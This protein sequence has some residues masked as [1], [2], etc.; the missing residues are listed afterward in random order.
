MFEKLTIDQKQKL[1][2]AVRIRFLPELEV[3]R[4]TAINAIIERAIFI[5]QSSD[6]QPTINAIRDLLNKCKIPLHIQTIEEGVESLRK[7]GRISLNKKKKFEAWY[8]LETGQN[9]EIKAELE[10]SV[11]IIQKVVVRLFEPLILNEKRENLLRKIFIQLLSR[12][13]AELGM[14]WIK[15]Q[16]G[17]VTTRNFVDNKRFNDIIVESI[18][19]S[20]F[21]LSE[22]AIIRSKCEEFFRISDP[23]F[24]ALKFNFGQGYFIS[25]I[26]G[27]QSNTHILS[28]T[29]FS[30][31]KLWL[32]TNVLIIALLEGSKHY[33]TFH[34]LLEICKSVGIKLFA[35]R[36]TIIETL[37]VIEQEKNLIEKLYDEIPEDYLKTHRCYD[38]F[39]ETYR[40]KK[41]KDENY[42]IHTLFASFDNIE[43]LLPLLGILIE[44]IINDEIIAGMNSPILIENIQ[45]CSQEIRNRKK[46][47]E[48]IEHDAYH[49]E[50]VKHFKRQNK[51][52]WLLTRDLSLPFISHDTNIFG[53]SVFCVQLN[54]LMHALSPYL[55]VNNSTNFLES[56]SEM[57]GSQVLPAEQLFDLKDFMIFHEMGVSSKDLATEE[58]DICLLKVKKEIL[59]GVNPLRM[60][61]ETRKNLQYWMQK[62]YADHA[63]EKDNILYEKEKTI[64]QLNREIERVKTDNEELKL[65]FEL[66]DKK[67]KQELT[68]LHDSISNLE[69]QKVI[70]E[71]NRR[72]ISQQRV[73]GIVSFFIFI[74]YFFMALGIAKYSTE[75]WNGSLFYIDKS[76]W[77]AYPIL[78]T[79]FGLTI[80][81]LF[82]K[83]CLKN[84]ISLFKETMAILR[85]Q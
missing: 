53:D 38:G 37:G 12:I 52:V 28:M 15:L 64:E 46:S 10:K 24:D 76:S 70:D 41:I 18:P 30:D 25:Q 72:K 77:L 33:R 29:T 32:D 51:K 26:L 39:L 47:K 44:D 2:H 85:N 50:L 36:K 56:F 17:N 21:Q 73:V 66:K 58:I 1:L 9:E 20:E 13:F 34:N 84:I 55:Q 27:I 49:F 83:D 81:F 14:Q 31:T 59:K 16:S 8:S 67:H 63:K 79:A 48:A 11:N 35:S 62:F 23:E 65:K 19:E 4:T 82:G 54:S 57:I 78:L 5:I 7:K 6:Q 71:I 74:I 61:D 43:E 40:L 45:E 75:H 69:K 80:R 22:V 3:P 42:N 60:D 68:D